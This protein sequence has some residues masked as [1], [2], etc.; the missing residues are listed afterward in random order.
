MVKKIKPLWGKGVLLSNYQLRQDVFYTDTNKCL[1]KYEKCS[2][3]ELEKIFLTQGQLTRP[4][5]C[6]QQLTNDVALFSG[7]SNNLP[8]LF[9]SM[10][11]LHNRNT[12][13]Y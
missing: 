5:E 3:E 2:Y 10:T 9:Q 7:V 11:G 8:I 12:C 13:Q 1:I 4:L 6:H